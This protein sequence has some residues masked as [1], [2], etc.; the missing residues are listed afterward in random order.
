MTTNNRDSKTS[1]STSSHSSPSPYSLP[2]TPSLSSYGDNRSDRD[3]NQERPHTPLPEDDLNRAYTIALV[4]K[5]ALLGANIGS[6]DNGH[7]DHSESIEQ[8]KN[9][10]HSIQGDDEGDKGNKWETV[11]QA[12]LK[13]PLLTDSEKETVLKLFSNNDRVQEHSPLPEDES[14]RAYTIALVVKEALSTAG[15]GGSGNSHDG[16]NESVEQ[17]KNK[18]HNIKRD[19]QDDSVHG[20]K[21]ETVSQT[22]LKNPSLTDSEKKTILKIFSNK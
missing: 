5:E 17:N 11:S 10:V 14:N 7:D 22:L 21:W 8:S 9:K 16:H 2:R 6:S 19:N 18:I 20:S 13:N 3:H 15:I 4:V 1:K 12:I